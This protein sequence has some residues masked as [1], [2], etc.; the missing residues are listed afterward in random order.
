MV[1]PLRKNDTKEV[2][3]IKLIGLR[4]KNLQ[5]ILLRFCQSASLMKRQRLAEC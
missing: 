4:F 2:Q 1:A 3:T 5:I